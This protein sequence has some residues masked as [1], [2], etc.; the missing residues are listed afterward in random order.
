MATTFI[1]AVEC[2]LFFC[3]LGLT[4]YLCTSLAACLNG[5]IKTKQQK[6][7]LLDDV[8]LNSTNVKLVKYGKNN[9][10]VNLS[11]ENEVFLDYC[12]S[13]SEFSIRIRGQKGVKKLA[14]NEHQ[15]DLLEQIACRLKALETGHRTGVCQYVLTSYNKTEKK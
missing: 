14:L 3:L 7:K 10:C 12:R 4:I 5:T 2:G 6:P 8:K 1:L 11:R 9:D 15:Y 13:G